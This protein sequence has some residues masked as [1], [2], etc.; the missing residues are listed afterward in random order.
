MAFKAGYNAHILMDGVAGSLVNIT[1]Y[2]DN[3]DFPMP[4]DQ[5]DVSTFG[6]ANKDFINGLTGGGQISLSGPLDVAIGTFLGG[7]QAAQ[8]AGSSSSTVT[9]SPAGSV[10]GQLKISVETYI[11]SFDP[12]TSVGGRGEFSASL[13]CTGAVT[14]AT[15]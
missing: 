12:S 11:S 5:L 8:A 14:V 9:Y 13:Q 7:L 6:D 1:S 2:A 10:S 15:W 4:T 3:F